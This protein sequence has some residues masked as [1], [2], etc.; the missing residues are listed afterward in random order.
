[1]VMGTWS[2]SSVEKKS[3]VK[4]DITARSDEAKQYSE[5]VGALETYAKGI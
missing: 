2:K 5:E 1:M 3:P 4:K